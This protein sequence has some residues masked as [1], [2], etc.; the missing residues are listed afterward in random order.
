MCL[1][2]WRGE[3]GEHRIGRKVMQH[4]RLGEECARGWAV[5]APSCSGVAVGVM[6]PAFMGV[7]PPPSAG[8]APPISTANLDACSAF[9]PW[10]VPT[11]WICSV[12]IEMVLYFAWIST[13]A[14]V[15]EPASSTSFTMPM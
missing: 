8:V 4:G 6:P 14:M 7:A 1:C 5:Y 10:R 3:G 15:P 13:L 12:L 2:V 11:S 9:A